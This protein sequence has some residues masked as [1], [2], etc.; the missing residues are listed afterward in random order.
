MFQF[1]I[2][3][4]LL[5]A[6]FVFSKTEGY[7]FYAPKDSVA[8][9][10]SESK[11]HVYDDFT[12]AEFY[13]KKAD[14]AA[15][16]SK[17]SILIADVAH[18]FGA[19]YYI[20]GSY[21]ISLQKFIE[22]LSIYENHDNKLGIAKCLMGQGLIQQAMSR[23]KEAIKLFES[24]VKLCV[25]IGDNKFAS[26]NFINI[27]L[28]Q[29]ELKLH[30]EAYLNFHRALKLSIKS[31]N[32]DDTNIVVNKLGSI[33]FLRNDIDSAIYYYK[34]NI[35]SVNNINLWEKSFAF[36]GLSE[37]YLKNKNYKLA[38]EYGLKGY[39][40]AQKVQAK[41]DIVRA[42]EILSN[43]YKEDKNFEEA[44]KYLEISKIY[45]DSLFNDSK[46]KQINLLELKSKDVKNEKLAALNQIAHQKLEYGRIFIASMILLLAF[47]LIILYQYKKNSKL[48]EKLYKELEAKNLDIKNRKALIIAQNKT[49]SD[50][51]QTKNR[52]FSILSHDLKSPIAS[53][54]QVLELLKFG[55]ISDEEMKIIS[56]HLIMQVESTSRLLN[57][58]LHWSITQ[59]DGAKINRENF[60]LDEILKDSIGAMILMIDNKE[61]KIDHI[62]PEKEHAIRADIG[63]VR[64]ILNN[65][66][67]NAVK[68][69]PK[70]GVI[71][72]KYSEET[73]FCNLHITNSGS[74]ISKEKMDQ[75]LNFD[76]R[77]SSEKG[78]GLEEGT[79]LGLL[80]VKQFVFENK[81]KLQILNHPE[82]GTEFIV[83]FQKAK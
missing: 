6:L 78:T 21:D 23:N 20:I 76:K 51:N 50:L 75:I 25:E 37:A 59:L 45:S 53:I 31:K 26:R 11:K 67:S 17:D 44:Y 34:K 12:K 41:W 43:A 80:L 71:E 60:F 39:Q 70:L 57:N 77:I 28:S 47:L 61:I 55:N 42:S 30:D 4:L 15:K 66:L 79:G 1:N 35:L 63:H 62:H 32:Q 36:T 8:Y 58:L 82:G 38:E 29:V 27:G 46:L 16:K 2:R 3:L 69:T 40:S 22:A 72:I 81:G 64:V 83:S 18:N 49:L 14:V 24:A 19:S 74:E 73:L 52:L 5:L 9:Y 56:E 13:L 65:L 33:H 10:L 68:F 48:K 54:Q 7:S